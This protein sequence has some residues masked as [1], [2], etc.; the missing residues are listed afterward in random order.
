MEKFR[1]EFRK[2][3]HG[4]YKNLDNLK[5]VDKKINKACRVKHKHA[6]END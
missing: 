3:G 2:P 6:Y 4:F 1:H 5:Y